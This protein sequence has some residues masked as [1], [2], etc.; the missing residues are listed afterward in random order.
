MKLIYLLCSLIW[1]VWF[2]A[3]AFFNFN[4]DRFLLVAHFY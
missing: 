1:L 2:V 4:P 3:T